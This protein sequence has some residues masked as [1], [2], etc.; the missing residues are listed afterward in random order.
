MLG[1]IM[2]NSKLDSPNQPLVW[3]MKA[4]RRGS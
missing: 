2:N 1:D 3:P 4:H